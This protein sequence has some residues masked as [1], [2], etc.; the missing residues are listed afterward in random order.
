MLQR[1]EM[2]ADGR[3]ISARR[4]AGEPAR[5]VMRTPVCECGDGE[6]DEI[7]ANA[8]EADQLLCDVE[9]ERDVVRCEYGARV[10][11]GL[12]RRIDFDEARAGGLGNAL[13][14]VAMISFEHE[15]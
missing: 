6:C 3:V 13:R 1:V 15:Q 12:L 11:P 5:V 2:P 4:G 7:V 10:V 9:H 14:D 8:F